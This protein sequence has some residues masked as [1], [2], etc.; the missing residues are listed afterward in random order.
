MVDKVF[1]L[2]RT[3]PTDGQMEEL[4]E[5]FPRANLSFVPK[6]PTTPEETTQMAV[7]LGAAFVML[8]VSPLP[9]HGLDNGIRFILPD[10]DGKIVELEDI[11]VKTKP[12]VP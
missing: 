3:Q 12:F 4:A 11:I 8:R 10:V 6:E 2:V 5:Y 1:M 7:E 9:R